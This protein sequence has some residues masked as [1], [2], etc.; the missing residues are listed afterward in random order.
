MKRPAHIP[1]TFQNRFFFMKYEVEIDPEIYTYNIVVVS[2]PTSQT[3]Y[4]LKQV[5]KKRYTFIL[6]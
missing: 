3:Y 4:H 5:A 6:K 2:K 1:L